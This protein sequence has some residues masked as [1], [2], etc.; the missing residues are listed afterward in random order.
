MAVPSSLEAQFEKV[1]GARVD[2]DPSAQRRLADAWEAAA[3]WWGSLA[4]Q[5]ETGG[6]RM[7]SAA[8][9]TALALARQHQAVVQDMRNQSAYC[10]S[11]GEQCRGNAAEVELGQWTWDW[12][13]AIMATQL[14]ADAVLVFTTGPVGLAKAAATRS[15]WAAAWRQVLRR[16]VEVIATNG[17]G[18]ATSRGRI[19]LLSTLV[20]GGLGASVPLIAQALQ[21]RAG[22]RDRIDWARAAIG[23]VSG[24]AG[25]FAGAGL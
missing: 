9:V 1:L 13:C 2:G 8:G 17:I 21:L 5:W 23:G 16:L 18:A 4:D 11:V 15:G 19:L 14:A 6:Q 22:D 10:R 3:R 25:G 20:G 7:A 12:F 24:A